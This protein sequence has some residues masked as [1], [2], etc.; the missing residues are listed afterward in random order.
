MSLFSRRGSGGR[1]AGT[2]PDSR[3][4]GRRLRH[5]NNCPMIPLVLFLPHRTIHSVGRDDVERTNYGRVRGKMRC[6]SGNRYCSGMCNLVAS[7]VSDVDGDTVR[8]TKSSLKQCS[9]RC[10][11]LSKVPREEG[12][13]D[14]RVEVLGIGRRGM[15][16]VDIRLP[17][18][19]C[20][21]FAPPSKVHRGRWKKRLALLGD[22]QSVG[23]SNN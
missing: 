6:R 12:R 20:R 11:F 22:A 5:N 10:M 3:K 2:C 17:F 4:T 15:Q 16:V 19:A 23:D 8:L 21:I 13:R 14:G 1:R 7:A 9:K 18:V